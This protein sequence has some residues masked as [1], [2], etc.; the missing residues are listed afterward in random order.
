MWSLC[1]RLTVVDFAAAGA[2]G[3]AGMCRASAGKTMEYFSLAVCVAM[4]AEEADLS[5]VVCQTPGGGLINT[6]SF[7]GG[8][9]RRKAML[10]V[11]AVAKLVEVLGGCLD[12]ANLTSA[13]V[14]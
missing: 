1:L 2:V 7:F 5:F 11:W 9:C 14:M 12:D 13:V 6:T 10:G 4:L 3:T 8:R